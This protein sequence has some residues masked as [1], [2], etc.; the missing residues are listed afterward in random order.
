MR[1]HHVKNLLVML[2]NHVE[3]VFDDLQATFHELLG[4]AHALEEFALFEVD[5][6]VRALSSIVL[7]LEYRD[8]LVRYLILVQQ[9]HFPFLSDLDDR[10]QILLP[11]FEQILKFFHPLRIDHFP[12]LVVGLVEFVVLV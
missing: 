2:L 1:R 5:E 8:L 11:K 12:R 10:S 9:F 4:H 7:A 6:H 3:G